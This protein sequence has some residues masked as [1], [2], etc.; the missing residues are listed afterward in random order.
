[1]PAPKADEV[2]VRVRAASL[3]AADLD[4]LSGSPFYIRLAGL[5]GPA[6]RIPGSD[7]TGTVEAIG[8]AVTRFRAGDEVFGDLSDSGFG[9]F[10]EYVCAPESALALKPAG[11][12]A[13]DAASLPQAGVLALQGIRDHIT[14][15][16]GARVLINGAGGGVGTFA[17]QLA[18]SRGAEVTAV[19]RGDKLDPL[20]ALGAD[21]VMDYAREDFT[22]RDEVYD[23]ILDS[24]ARHSAADYRRSLASGGACVII[25]GSTRAILGAVMAGAR[26]P[27]DN[28]VRLLMWRRSPDDL[29]ALAEMA[30]GGTIRPVIGGRYVLG[31]A[32]AA[33]RKLAAGDALGKLIIMVGNT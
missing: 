22:R 19:D 9:A 7:M 33:Y 20:R 27:D 25:G 15:G 4:Q 13:E 30:A 3:N 11:L 16:P 10:A 8:T 5:R 28:R 21:H 24:V 29:A 32:P 6:A 14:V 12:S 18:K 17:V 1:M 23:L 2:L 31:E 26:R